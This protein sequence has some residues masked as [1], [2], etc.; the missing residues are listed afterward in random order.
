MDLV[1]NT[2]LTATTDANS[3]SPW[4]ILTAVGVVLIVVKAMLSLI[5]QLVIIFVL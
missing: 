3:I 2:T 4:L 5:T 1:S